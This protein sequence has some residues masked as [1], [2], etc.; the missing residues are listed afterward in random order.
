MGKQTNAHDHSIKLPL[1]ALYANNRYKLGWENIFPYYEIRYRLATR[2]RRQFS[3]LFIYMLTQ[4]LKG[5]L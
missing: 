1:F 4:Q 3:S 5:Q 2:K